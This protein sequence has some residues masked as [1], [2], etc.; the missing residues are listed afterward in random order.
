MYLQLSYFLFHRT[1]YLVYLLKT[2]EAHESAWKGDD[3]ISIPKW[4]VKT[5]IMCFYSNGFGLH[6]QIILQLQVWPWIAM[7]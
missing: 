6:S 4:S 1:V 7:F 2:L 5:L 3:T